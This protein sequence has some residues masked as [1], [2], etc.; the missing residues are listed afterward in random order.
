MFNIV[1]FF[2]LRVKTFT[3]GS[4]FYVQIIC[5]S[6]FVCLFLSYFHTQNSAVG[7]FFLE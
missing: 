6:F 5:I 2:L 3:H 4:L 1:F 7:G